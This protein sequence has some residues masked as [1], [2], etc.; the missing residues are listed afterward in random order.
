[1]MSGPRNALADLQQT[2]LL[3]AALMGGVF[4]A[5]TLVT[6]RAG[7]IETRWDLV[8]LGCAFVVGLVRRRNGGRLIIAVCGCVLVVVAAFLLALLLARP[9]IETSLAVQGVALSCVGAG[10]ACVLGYTIGGVVKRV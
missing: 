5:M 4:I 6:V 9:L 1:M 8:T 7:A 3:M 2:A 10:I